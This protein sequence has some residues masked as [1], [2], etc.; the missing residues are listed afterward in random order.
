M[1]FCTAKSTFSGLTNITGQHTTPSSL[2]SSTSLSIGTSSGQS[3]LVTWSARSLHR[4]ISSSL[5]RKAAQTR[6]V[7]RLKRFPLLH[8]SLFAS[9]HL[10]F[11]S[12]L[13]DSHASGLSSAQPCTCTR[14]RLD[15]SYDI[16][17]M[18]L[19]WCFSGINAPVKRWSAC[20]AASDRQQ[21][22]SVTLS[23]QEKEDCESTL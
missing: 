14:L 10:M 5:Q 6:A 13:S 4:S 22:Q 1:T 7:I 23:G 12:G 11:V 8:V 21:I 17:L 18:G 15:L 2:S 20:K 16:D 19:L 9:I 3:R